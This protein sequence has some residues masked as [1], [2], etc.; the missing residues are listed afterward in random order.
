[1]YQKSLN[2]TKKAKGSYETHFNDKSNEAIASRKIPEKVEMSNLMIV[3][4][5]DMENT[6]IEYYSNDVLRTLTRLPL[7]P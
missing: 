5:L 3:D 6:I 1:L 2:N 7:S 4:Y